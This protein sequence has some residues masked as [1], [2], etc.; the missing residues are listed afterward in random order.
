MIDSLK[1]Y[2]KIDGSRSTLE[3]NWMNFLDD[4]AAEDYPERLLM[5]RCFETAEMSLFKVQIMALILR[6]SASKYIIVSSNALYDFDS[7]KVS[8]IVFMMIICKL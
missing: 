4:A 2:V 6:K 5:H 7:L 3:A 8:V 1:H